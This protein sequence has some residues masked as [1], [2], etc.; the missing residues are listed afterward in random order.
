MTNEL[1]RIQN[2]PT[3][4]INFKKAL[5]WAKKFRKKGA[6]LKFKPIQA[7]CLYEFEECGGLFAYLVVGS[8]K[9][10]ISFL[11]PSCLDFKRPVLMIPSSTRHQTETEA[12]PKFSKDFHIRKDI[13]IHTYSQLSRG[14]KVLEEYEPDLI[15]FDEAHKLSN[16][17]STRVQM[18]MRYLKQNPSTRVACLSGTM[19]DKS[20]TDYTHLL[21]WT[22]GRKWSPV[23][24]D[25]NFSNQIN[26]EL[27][28]NL[29]KGL[30]T[31]LCPDGTSKSCRQAF[32]KRLRVSPG[33]IIHDAEK[34]P[35]D[36]VWMTIEDKIP[37]N[38]A[39]S[40][41]KFKKSWHLPEIG[42]LDNAAEVALRYLQ[43]SQGFYTFWKERPPTD[44][45]LAKQSFNSYCKVHLHKGDLVSVSRVL[46][47]GLKKGHKAAVDWEF[48]RKEFSPEVCVR[49]ITEEVVKSVLKYI[50]PKTILWVGSP[51]VGRK[52][53][54]LSNIPYFG[55]GRAKSLSLYG[56]DVVCL[57]IASMGTGLNLQRFHRNVILTP[58]KSQR[59][60]EQLVGRTARM[61]Q[62]NNRVEILTLQNTSYLK[63]RWKETLLLNNMVS[64]SYGIDNFLN[65]F[66][67]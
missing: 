46:K 6:T 30:A 1:S 13:R 8:G 5:A 55:Q 59:R 62:K 28:L 53:S 47:H 21:Q 41:E 37:D 17:K 64:E 56:G 24:L 22:H 33:V 50:T 65:H 42:F 29:P 66:E 39:Q 2:L 7:A 63:K 51:F 27:K 43:M 67:G 58:P 34:P 11:L 45:V 32:L 35:L 15:V 54:E 57:S 3:R 44:Y 20:T 61:G 36:I 60:W 25:Y 14:K 23:P 10:L 52:V 31:S 48:W 16:K 4:E 49:W 40:I 18:V 26:D 38:L 19:V 9:S 12:L